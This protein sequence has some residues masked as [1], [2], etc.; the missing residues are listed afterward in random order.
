LVDH[1]GTLDEVIAAAAAEAK[2]TDYD[3]KLIATKLSPKQE[4]IRQLTEGNASSLLPKV[5][6]EKFAALT[7]L[8][9]T[10]APLNNLQ[11]MNDPQ[12]IYLQCLSCVA[13]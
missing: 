6:L 7:L 12:G 4:F 11:K 8:N 13:P 5:L 10:L 2:L 9:E 1:L 3:V